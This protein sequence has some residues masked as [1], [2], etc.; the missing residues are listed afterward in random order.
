MITRGYEIPLNLKTRDWLKQLPRLSEEA[1]ADLK[2][3]LSEEEFQSVD[4]EMWR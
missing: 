2:M 3:A 4:A 1:K